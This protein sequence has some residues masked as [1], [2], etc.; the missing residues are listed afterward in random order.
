MARIFARTASAAFIAVFAFSVNAQP[1][2]LGRYI[3]VL[4]PGAG[5]PAA[6]AGEVAQAS[7]GRVG[8]VYTNA[9]Q[10]F[11]LV[12]PPQAVNAIARDPRVAYIE[13]DDPV[14]LF[15]QTIP[16][17][18]DRI[19]N[20]GSADASIPALGVNGSDDQRVDV[21]VAVIDTGID[22]EHPD[23]NVV[24]GTNCTYLSGSGPPWARS[25]FCVNGEGD[26]DHYHGTHVAGTIGA[27]D[28][29]FGV[30]GVA[31]G[32]RLWTVKVLDSNGSGYESNVVA[33]IDWVAGHADTIEVA[34]MSLGGAGHS[35][36]QQDAI[37]AA[38][39]GGVVFVVAAGNSDAD[40]A[41][42]SPAGLD[43]VVTV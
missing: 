26:D 4:N 25:A 3:V 35:Q 38:V 9:L 28:N 41:D 43:N 42:Y 30:V 36:A 22:Y 21:D 8:F 11:S 13:S 5:A 20:P 34:N 29:G 17:G 33:G 2:Q 32:A 24:G 19:V 10:G 31:P 7:G 14:E 16:T 37:T 18:L 6:V 39:N 15:A 12:V 1:P 23:L 40:A 27:L